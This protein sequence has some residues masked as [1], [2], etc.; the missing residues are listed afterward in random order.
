MVKLTQ[1]ADYRDRVSLIICEYEPDVFLEAAA[2]YRNEP[3]GGARCRECFAA[4]LGE[5]ARRAADGGYDCFATTLSVSPHK[6]AVMI[7]EIGGRASREHGVEYL[8]SDFKKR[9]GY[10][11]S[12]ELSKLYGLYR[13]RYCG[14]IPP[15]DDGQCP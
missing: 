13:Q 2:P 3:E 4:R 8:Q 10:K 11:R 15:N 12:V 1:R 6:D 5:T 9:D 7:N 14:C